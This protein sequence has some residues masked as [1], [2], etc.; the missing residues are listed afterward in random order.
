MPL[1]VPCSPNTH[2]SYNII[3]LFPKHFEST[4]YSCDNWLSWFGAGIDPRA[5]RELGMA[6]AE[7]LPRPVTAVLMSFCANSNIHVPGVGTTHGA[8]QPQDLSKCQVT[9]LGPG[10]GDGHPGRLLGLCLVSAPLPVW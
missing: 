3:Y 10:A 1:E 6:L 2:I 8:E 9:V 4:E 7:L 5:S